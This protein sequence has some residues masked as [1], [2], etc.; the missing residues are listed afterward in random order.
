MSMRRAFTLIELLVVISIIALLIAI[1][2]PALGAARDAARGSQCASNVKSCS[3]AGYVYAT[4]NKGLLPR[5]WESRWNPFNNG[6][7]LFAEACSGMLGG[8]EPMRSRA[9][10]ERI[11][12]MGGNQRGLEQDD[13]LA[14][15]M[16]DMPVLPPTGTAGPSPRPGTMGPPRAR[17]A[18]PRCSW[19]RS[20]ICSRVSG[21]VWKN[22]IDPSGATKRVVGMPN[23]RA[24]LK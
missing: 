22:S 19:T 12:A 24:A 10:R 5:D 15:H 6:K 1:L 20:T 8:P 7:K 18:T 4:E 2:L 16:K 17:T 23:P 13:Y 14:W 3:Q 21:P 11:A 9:E